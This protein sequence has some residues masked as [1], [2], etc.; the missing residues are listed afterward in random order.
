MSANPPETVIEVASHDSF[1]GRVNMGDVVKYRIIPYRGSETVEREG[2][3]CMWD[4]VNAGG[5]GGCCRTGNYLIDRRNGLI[6]IINYDQII[7]ANVPNKSMNT[8]SN[9]EALPP[10][11]FSASLKIDHTQGQLR[12]MRTLVQDMGWHDFMRHVA[13]LMAE[14]SDRTTGEQSSAL[15]ACCNTVNALREV[16][17]G[18]GQFEYPPEMVDSLPN[19]VCNRA[20]AVRPRLKTSSRLPAPTLFAGV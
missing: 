2:V 7:S 9:S 13:G 15:F 18:C 16:W 19:E 17:Q 3:F 6:D 4:Y 1:A 8:Q 5:M 11:P 12:Q 20:T 14:Q 10:T